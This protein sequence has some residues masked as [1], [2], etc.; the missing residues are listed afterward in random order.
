MLSWRDTV[1]IVAVINT[2]LRLADVLGQGHTLLPEAL[3]TLVVIAF[4]LYEKVLRKRRSTSARPRLGWWEALIGFVYAFGSY[5]AL[6]LFGIEG[7]SVGQLFVWL[8]WL[9]IS[10]LAFDVYRK[11]GA[12]RYSAQRQ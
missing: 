2:P 3:L 6:Q 10:V 1:I 9:L 8:V 4:A 5:Y 7:G 11:N 12:R